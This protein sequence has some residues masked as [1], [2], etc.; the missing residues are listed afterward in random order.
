MYTKVS[1][2]GFASLIFFI[3][4]SMFLGIGIPQILSSSKQNSPYS[5][6]LGFILGFI[7][8]YLF[9]KIMNYEKDLNIFEKMEKLYGKILGNIINLLLFLLFSFYFLY[10][11]W[12]VQLYI[13]NKYLDKTPSIIILILFLIPT[14]Y[15]VNKGIKTISK[16]SLIIFMISIIEIFLCIF[17][18]TGFVEI[19]NLKPFFEVPILK[20][21]KNSLYFIS[22]FLTPIFML[23]IVP[24][25][26]LENSDKINKTISIFYIIGCINFLLLF[27][28]IIGV[29]GIELAE[30]F[31]YP[32]FTL[33]KKINYFDFIQHVENILSSQWL[34]SLFI[35]EVMSLLFS[36]EYLVQK[37]IYKKSIYYILIAV[38]LVFS[39]MLFK[40]TTI[41]YDLVKKYFSIIYSIPI[42]ILV[43]VSVILILF[44]KNKN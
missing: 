19:N 4:Q 20:I 40:N 12:S 14:I 22:Y 28:F 10:T 41:G 23:S 42:F 21:L 44:K 13:Q 18:L 3:S 9:M 7:I 24:K 30:L 26:K 33:I 25:N 39:T 37:K 32:E 15:S 6:I 27:I 36:K 2:K 11:L 43:I 17:G 1:N 35:T 16:L 29:F 34:F 5:I 38:A 31:Y 8:L